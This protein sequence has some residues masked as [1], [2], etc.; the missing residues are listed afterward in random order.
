MCGTKTNL[1]ARRQRES[2]CHPVLPFLPPTGARR[3]C[4]VL[5]PRV[6]DIV[7]VW[8]SLVCLHTAGKKAF[9]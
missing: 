5:P 8:R 2:F 1:L 9:S 4:R 6:H 3:G 7:G